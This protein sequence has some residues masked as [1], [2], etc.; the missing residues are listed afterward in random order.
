MENNTNEYILLANI[1]Q[2]TEVMSHSSC[3]LSLNAMSMSLA[4]DACR[5]SKYFELLLEQ[6]QEC[7][8]LGDAYDVNFSVWGN[9]IWEMMQKVRYAYSLNNVPLNIYEYHAESYLDFSNR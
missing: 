8:P 1:E 4:V 7:L 2:K 9:K 3:L 5:V 6:W